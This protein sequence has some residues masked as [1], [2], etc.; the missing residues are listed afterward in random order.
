MP[1][2]TVRN[3][4][5]YFFFKILP[6][7]TVP[8]KYISKLIFF[9]LKLENFFLTYLLAEK[10]VCLFTRICF[11]K[12]F[13]AFLL[14]S[15]FVFLEINFMKSNLCN[16]RNRGAHQQIS[17]SHENDCKPLKIWLG[18][19]NTLS[20]IISTL[21]RISFIT[22]NFHLQLALLDNRRSTDRLIYSF[23]TS[24]LNAKF[25]TKLSA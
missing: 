7:R 5:R 9:L 16:C 1:E 11:V 15:I 21:L 12:C 14:K 25:L 13:A 18:S 19:E 24:N 23:K 2:N 20:I 17:G 3:F 4:A 10:I 8:N 6:Y 22:P